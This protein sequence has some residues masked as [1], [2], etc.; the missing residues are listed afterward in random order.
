VAIEPS[1][2]RLLHGTV[3]THNHPGGTIDGPD[4]LRGLSFS[5]SDVRTAAWA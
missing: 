3:I 1:E 5:E 2:L 4:A